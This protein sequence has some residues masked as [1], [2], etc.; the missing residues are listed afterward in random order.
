MKNQLI[1]YLFCLLPIF[2]YSQ[3]YFQYFDGADTLPDYSILIEI[4][5][6]AFNIWQV[7]SPQKEIF[8]SPST[9]PNVMV[10]D[11]INYYPVNN[12]SSFQYTIVPWTTWGILALQWTQK[13][14]MDFG[15]DGGFLEFSNDGGVNWQNIFDN[16]YVYSIYGFDESN[17][18]TIASGEEV[19]TGVDS[20][21]RDIWLCY[22]MSWMAY[23]DSIM[24][25][26]TFVSDSIEG[27][28]EGWMIDN[29]LAHI[30]IIHTVDE[31]AQEKYL[32]VSPNPTTGR[33]NIST[34]KLNEFHIIERME[35]VNSAGDVLEAWKNIPT[36]FFIDINHHPDGLYY[37]KIQTNKK[38]EVVKI[39]L[40]R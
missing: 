25:R 29:L 14:D 22:D 10:T 13:L 40:Q 8:N 5:T 24:V 30:T 6:T 21:W 1:S 38:S 11:T 26:H 15:K 37:L 35:L 19:F 12:V 2:S 7:G 34:K 18:D 16:P 27:N 3:D 9:S 4:D 28:N 17:L 33:V 20:T 39:V 32:K 23:Y 31:V 36:K